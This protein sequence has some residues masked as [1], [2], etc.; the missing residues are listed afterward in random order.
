M[1]SATTPAIRF[2]EPVLDAIPVE[3][4]QPHQIVTLPPPPA[5]QPPPPEGGGMKAVQYVRYHWMLIAILGTIFGGIFAALAYMLIP[6]KYS[7]YSIIRVSPEDPRIY[8]NEDPNGRNDFSSYLKTQAGMLK[9]PL[10][11]QA[12]IRDPEIAQ[13]P[14]LRNQADPV[15][16]LEEE[17]L[18]EFQD[19]SELIKPKL[20]GDDAQSIVM[21]VNSIHDAYFR[22]VVEAE[23]KRKQYRLKQLE[24]SMNRMQQELKTRQQAAVVAA[25][26]NAVAESLPGVGPNVA[27]NEVVRLREKLDV[28]DIRIKQIAEER[29]RS[30]MRLAN[31]NEEL[32]SVPQALLIQLENDPGIAGINQQLAEAQARLD[33]FHKLNPDKENSGLKGLKERLQTLTAQKETI[34]KQ[35]LV[36]YQKTQLQ[37]LEYQLKE[38]QEQLDV[39]E[40]G[41][42]IR[43]ETLQ[44]ELKEYE[45]KLADIL[46]PDA[47]QPRDFGKVDLNIRTEIVTGLMDKANLLR[48]ELSAP[49]RVQSFQRATQTLQRDRKKQLIGTA[50][51]GLAG[52]LL[53][54][55]FAVLFETRRKR[56]MQLADLQT[57][58]HIPLLGVLPHLQGNEADQGVELAL[59]EENLE[60]IRANIWQQFGTAGSRSIV[61]TSA[62]GDEGRSFL[63]RE[64]ALSFGRSGQS[65]LLIDFD[66][67]TPEMH[68]TFE[69]SL[70]PG[71]A[72]LLTRQAYLGDC[73]QALPY[74]IHLLPA[75]VWTDNL[76]KSLSSNVLY[77]LIEQVKQMFEVVI[78]HTHSLL[79]VAETLQIGRV[80]DGV[81]VAVQRHESRLPTLEKTFESIQRIAPEAAGMVYLGARREECYQ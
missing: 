49:T 43:K 50:A 27:A 32:P 38:Q 46:P 76:R 9:S 79:T 56:V 10:V 31:L 5:E 29:R 11:L 59:A 65:T 64:L 62:V 16:F 26:P 7:T 40:T 42:V 18:V 67:R 60:K 3:S 1:T 58:S 70:Q 6:A 69:T 33:Y 72:E 2:A 45:K 34:R 4:N 24:D 63:A 13:L 48:L 81:V 25:D 71:I 23:R 78:I 8:W 75:G 17:L 51:G 77:Q 28:V 66:L 12:A 47:N 15:R 61:V 52:F 55:L 30:K 39:E 22:E 20:M 53:I 44:K 57:F 73:L 21:I 54:G 37:V 35:R 36:E 68:H 19:G 80:A 74:H 41:L 14:M